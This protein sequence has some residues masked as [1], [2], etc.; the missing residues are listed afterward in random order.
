[1]QFKK[2]NEGAKEQKREREKLR[3]RLLTIEDKLMVP[4]GE[5]GAGTGD[6]GDGD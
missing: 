1:M 2:Q 4:R 3:N 5:V 6:L